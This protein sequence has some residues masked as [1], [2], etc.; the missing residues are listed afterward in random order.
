MCFY[1]SQS[2]RVLDLA[3]RYGRKTDILEMVQEILDE[4]YKITAFANPYSAIITSNPS[5]QVAKW[6]LIPAWIKSE[7]EAGKIRKMTINARSDTV[8]E[9]PSFR[10][11]ILKKRCL[12][13]STGYFEYHHEGKNA[14]PYYIFLKNEDIFSLGGLY[15]TWLNPVSKELLQTFTV[16]TVPA[17]EL[18][19]K[20]HNGGKTPFRMPLI[21]D[22][23]NEEQWLDSSLNADDIKSF[24]LP[25]DSH[26]MDAY[27]ISKDFLK[28]SPMDSSI[29]EPAA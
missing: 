6:G 21:I 2:K 28:K 11:P 27:P 14:I 1:N 10:V 26:K 22:K 5:I 3:K 7:E 24:L 17:N 16:L 23:V 20:I 18:C 9:L 13:P 4:Q 15:E 19:A 12:I 8:F 29:I 25:F